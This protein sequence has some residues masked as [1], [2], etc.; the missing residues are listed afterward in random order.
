MNKR[1][2][3]LAPLLIT[4]GCHFPQPSPVHITGTVID[5]YVI[6]RGA[7]SQCMWSGKH[8]VI[9]TNTTRID[10]YRNN[11]NP[12]AI[13]GDSVEIYGYDYHT[14]TNCAKYLTI[15]DTLYILKEKQ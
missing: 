14:A 11:N 6:D 15:A 2:L 7:T 13:V 4:V 3:A 9:K 12:P 8:L 5:E 1:I 10:L